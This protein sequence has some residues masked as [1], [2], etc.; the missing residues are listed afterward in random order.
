MACQWYQCFLQMEYILYRRSRVWEVLVNDVTTRNRHGGKSQNNR[1]RFQGSK[2]FSMTT[3][4][5]YMM[6]TLLLYSQDRKN[7]IIV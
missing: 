5:Q 2:F 6:K 4:V 7:V 3:G 1:Y